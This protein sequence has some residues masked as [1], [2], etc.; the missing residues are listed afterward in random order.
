MD[1][2]TLAKCDYVLIDQRVEWLECMPFL[3]CCE[4]ANEYVVYESDAEYHQ[5]KRNWKSRRKERWPLMFVLLQILQ[6]VR[7]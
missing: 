1:H 7:K 2:D 4:V 6:R 3:F 5:K